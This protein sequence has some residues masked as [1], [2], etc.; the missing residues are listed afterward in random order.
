MNEI[1]ED[2][3]KCSKC[4]MEN[5]KS[6]FHKITKTSDGF[7]PQCKFCRKKNIIMKK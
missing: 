4:E 3:K 7:H 5:L 6:K 2:L 1:N